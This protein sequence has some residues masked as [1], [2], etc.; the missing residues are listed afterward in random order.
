MKLNLVLF[1]VVGVLE[2]KGIMGGGGGGGI[3]Y[4]LAGR[5]KKISFTL[6][7][8]SSHPSKLNLTIRIQVDI[9]NNA[10]EQV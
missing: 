8:H 5:G 1:V 4:L 9:K 3:Q 2:S 6:K 10:R 7:P